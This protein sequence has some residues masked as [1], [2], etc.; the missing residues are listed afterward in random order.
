MTTS[1]WHLSDATQLR[2]G[3]L[4]LAIGAKVQFYKASTTTPLT[5]FRDASASTPHQAASL[6]TNGDGLWPAIYIPYGS[7]D[8]RI[9]DSNGTTIAHTEAVPNPAP[10]DPT[11]TDPDS[12]LKTGDTWFSPIGGNRAGAVRLN[13]RTLGAGSSSASERANDDTRPLFIFLW[14]NLENTQAPVSGGRGAS[15]AADFAANKTITLPDLRGSV[16]I[17]LDGMGNSVAGRLASAPI[18]NGTATTGGSV[19]GGNTQILEE[20]NMPAHTHGAGA[21]VADS[22]GSHSHGV[23]SIV[24]AGVGDHTHG[25]TD[26]GHRHT[27]KND[28]ADILIQ[29]GQTGVQATGGPGQMPSSQVY[30]QVHGTQTLTSQTGVSLGQAGSHT[31]SLSG[32]TAPDGAHGHT[33]SGDSASTGAGAAHNNVSRS[34]LGTWFIKL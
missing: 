25:V 1:I 13:G 21:L 7:F 15:A 29:A 14:T 17:G 27:I 2:K 18:E 33:V 32:D 11:S 3:K 23:G 6:L 31:H 22:V 8:Y 19:L 30:G 5:V 24:A 34:V 20:A 26:T 4:E 12:L 10:I 16:P 28:G 9:L